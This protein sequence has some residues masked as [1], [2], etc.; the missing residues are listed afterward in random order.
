M[1]RLYVNNQGDGKEIRSLFIPDTIIMA[2]CVAIGRTACDCV[3]RYR[4]G[5][6]RHI[7]DIPPEWLNGYITVNAPLQLNANIHVS[8]SSKTPDA[9]RGRIP[10]CRRHHPRQSLAAPLPLPHLPRRQTVPD[11]R[12]GRRWDPRHLGN[13]H[14]VPGR[15]R[16]QARQSLLESQASQGSKDEVRTQSLE[17]RKHLRLL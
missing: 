5:G 14:R 11:R 3:Q 16:M 1:G 12:M 10:L 4:F 13:R 2:L 8:D 6:G 15:L 7:W 9:R 17:C